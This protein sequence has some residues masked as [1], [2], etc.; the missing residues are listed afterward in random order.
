M[1]I[2]T[3]NDTISCSDILAT[4]ISVSIGNGVSSPQFGT[5]GTTSA[6]V[7]PSDSNN[8]LSSGS[9]AGIVVGV[10]GLVAALLV[11]GIYLRISK[12]KCSSKPRIKVGEVV[13]SA[14]YRKASGQ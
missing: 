12:K 6:T 13:K 7:T 8:A 5:T 3:G 9:I 10:V 4:P 14:T 2:R 11:L 1:R